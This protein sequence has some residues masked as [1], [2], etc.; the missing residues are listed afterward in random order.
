MERI[1]KYHKDQQAAYT[2]FNNMGLFGRASLD[3]LIHDGIEGGLRFWGFPVTGTGTLEVTVGEGRLYNQGQVF[4]RNDAGGVALSLASVVPVVTKKIITVAVWGQETDT[5]VQ[6]RTFLVDVE[7]LQTEA[8]AVATENRRVAQLNLVAGVESANPTKPALDANVIAVAYITMDPGGILS[9]E[10]AT[11]N[12]IVSASANAADIKA[13]EL[14]RDLAGQRLDTLASDLAALAARMYGMVRRNDY[15]NVVADV[16]RLKEVTQLPDNLSDYSADHFL[17][18]DRSDLDHAD[19]LARIEEGVRFPSAQTTVAQILL[20]NQ[21]ESKVVVKSDGLM[22][23]TYTDLARVSVL[24]NDDQLS[25]AQYTQQNVDWVEKTRVRERIRYGTVFKTC[26][27]NIWWKQ[28]DY[29]SRSGIFSRAG[30]TFQVVQFFNPHGRS[31]APA[32]SVRLRQVW[33]DT[34]EDGTYWDA[35]VSNQTVAGAMVSQTFL[36]SQAGWVTGLNLYFTDAAAAGDVH[37]LLCE[38]VGGAPDLDNVIASVTLDVDDIELYP[39]KTEIPIGPVQ[40]EAGRYAIVLV[41]S[42]N[43]FVA[44][45]ED[46]KFAEGSFFYSTDGAWFM[47]DLTKDLAFELMFA[48]FDNPRVEVQMQ[49]LTN[50]NGIANIDILAEVVRPSGMELFYEVQVNSEWKRLDE[51][52]ENLLNGLPALLPFRLVFVGTT[53]NH[54][55]L[56]TGAPSTTTCWRPRTDFKHVSETRTLASPAS[57]I[58]VRAVVEWWDAGRHTLDC[59]LLVDGSPTWSVGIDYDSVEVIDLPDLQDVTG[60]KE[61]RFTFDN[62]GGGLS[63][64]LSDFKIRFTGTTDNALVTYHIGERVD[65]EYDTV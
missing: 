25:I 9:I 27:N 60:R 19:W 55:G 15:N 37:V 56:A 7:T 28:G 57:V 63:P 31:S 20:L 51:T 5:A 47:G 32:Y 38:T 3:N 39:E 61:M 35:I 26:T 10:K 4:Y 21:Y 18:E 6:P 33:I 11:D 40:L 46:N 49:P 34:I 48:Q 30:E 65:I 12:E 24:G 17:T 52:S 62:S 14:W 36:N 2:D 22:L 29:D 64:A 13:L 58:E 8:E 16:A 42:G 44:I 41:S 1:V 53:D 59:D 50:E 45:V 54:C 23:P 43:H